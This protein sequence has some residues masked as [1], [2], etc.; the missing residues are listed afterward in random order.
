MAYTMPPMNNPKRVLVATPLKGDIPASYFKSSLQLATAKIPD[1]KLDWVILEG[2]AVQMAR[3]EIVAYAREQ[4]FDELLFWDKDVLAEQN[5]QNVTAGAVM[6]MLKHDKDIVC[7]PYSSRHLDTHWHVHTI[8]GKEPDA[9]GLQEVSRACIGFS[10]IKMS[11]FDKIEA[12]NLDRKAVLIDPNHAPKPCT[13]FFPM[14]VQ[15]KNTPE[16][17]LANLRSILADNE[18]SASA[19]LQ[20]LEREANL[21]YD[22][23]NLFIGEDYW[24]CDLARKSGFTI[25]LDTFLMM[26]HT[27]KVTLPIPTLRLFELMKEPWRQEEIKAIKQALLDK[28]KEPTVAG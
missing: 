10:K 25:H 22:E 21:R 16:S 15:G 23:P 4:K 11:V 28:Q 1:V 6:R 3:N 5:G 13:E 24:F 26:G 2:P 14:G 8:E 7:A 17:R 9:D 19:K 18:L 12:D 27:G 20:R